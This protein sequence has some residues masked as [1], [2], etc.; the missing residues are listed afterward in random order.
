MT[1]YS[2]QLLA[3]KDPPSLNFHNRTD[4][5]AAMTKTPLGNCSKDSSAIFIVTKSC[6]ICYQKN[7]QYTPVMLSCVKI[8]AQS[9]YSDQKHT[10]HRGSWK[11][12]YH[13][14]LITVP[15]NPQ[16]LSL[17]AD[18]FFGLMLMN[19]RGGPPIL[20]LYVDEFQRRTPIQ[21]MK[22]RGGPPLV[23]EFQRRTPFQGA[24]C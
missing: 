12:S 1:N 23:D 17:E 5:S 2:C 19:S 20:G 7:L 13:P 9:K 10:K 8:S 24:V 18:P 3:F 22:S 16:K 14:V 21:L 4:A 6:S 11:Q 15:L